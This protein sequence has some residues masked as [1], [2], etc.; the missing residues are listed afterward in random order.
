MHSMSQNIRHR[1]IADRNLLDYGAKSL[2]DSWFKQAIGPSYVAAPADPVGRILNAYHTMKEN[3]LQLSTTSAPTKV[4]VSRTL[5]GVVCKMP[6]F[7]HQTNHL[8]FFTPEEMQP[9]HKPTCDDDKHV[10]V[11]IDPDRQGPEDFFF[12]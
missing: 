1:G 5:Y 4:M 2:S 12:C 10:Y 8:Y 6:C 11:Q 7:N 9:D 3:Y